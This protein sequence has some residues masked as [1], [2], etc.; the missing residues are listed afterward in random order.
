MENLGALEIHRYNVFYAQDPAF[1][2][3][4]VVIE[5]QETESFK[6]QTI[7]KKLNMPV[8]VFLI[9]SAGKELTEIRFFYPNREASLCIHGALAAACHLL[10][11]EDPILVVTKDNSILSLTNYLNH[12]FMSFALIP[13]EMKN[14]SF[15][16]KEI[17]E[18]LELSEK[19]I[20]LTLPFE[21][22]SVRSPKLLIPVK[23]IETLKNLNPNFDQISKWSQNNQVNGFYVYTK[24]TILKESNFNARNF[25]PLSGQSEDIA[26]GI[27]AAALA[28]CFAKDHHVNTYVIEQG[29]FLEHPCLI[30]V[31]ANN[32]VIRVGGNAT[33]VK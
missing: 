15:S 10:H 2:N 29:Y 28:W 19:D 1:G 11:T 26:T 9:A 18:M 31:E 17:L 30:H 23:N 7:A 13:P 3:P 14:Q 33:V 12:Y 21:I 4:A 25:N 24:E 20:D 6:L 5:T 8:T 22:V 27:A 32:N 16:S